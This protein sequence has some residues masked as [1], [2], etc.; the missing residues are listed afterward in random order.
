MR[1]TSAR[2]QPL[3]AEAVSGPQAQASR[4][5]RLRRLGVIGTIVL[6]GTLAVAIAVP[7]FITYR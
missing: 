1:P 4:P 5:R 7:N 3:E 6:V 2:P